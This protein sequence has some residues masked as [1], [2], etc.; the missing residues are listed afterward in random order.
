MGKKR[1]RYSAAYKRQAIEMA[2]SSD[3]TI[4]DIERELGLTKGLLTQWVHRARLGGE[5]IF[6]GDGEFSPESEEIRRLKRENQ[7]LRLDNEILK[8]T[9]AIFT[10]PP[11]KGSDI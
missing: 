4:A 5:E 1:G 3:R 6:K 7:S 11:K 8:K 9:I 10:H 2:L